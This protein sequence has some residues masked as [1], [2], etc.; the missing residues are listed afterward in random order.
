[1]QHKVLHYSIKQS[2]QMHDLLVINNK[3]CHVIFRKN[4]VYRS[5]ENNNIDRMDG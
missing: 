3:Q 4:W 5:T 1:M 2:Y